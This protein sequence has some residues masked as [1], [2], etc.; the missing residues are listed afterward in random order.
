MH[1]CILIDVAFPARD[2]FRLPSPYS[3]GPGDDSYNLHP[4]NSVPM[5]KQRFKLRE[6]RQKVGATAQDVADATG[7]ACTTITR[8][9]LG[10]VQPM[11]SSAL[12][13]LAWTEEQAR[14]CRIPR[15]DRVRPEDLIQ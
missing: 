8:I 11:Y 14:I 15:S 12:R 5:Q 3:L 2:Y 1:A 4:C 7:L 9:E 10:D 13:I 6:F